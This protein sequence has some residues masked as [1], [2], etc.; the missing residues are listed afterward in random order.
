VELG[1]TPSPGEPHEKFLDQQAVI[2]HDTQR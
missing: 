2:K 1:P